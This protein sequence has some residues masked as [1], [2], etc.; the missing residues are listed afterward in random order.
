LALTGIRLHRTVFRRTNERQPLLHPW[1][2]AIVNAMS[3]HPPPQA[4]TGP[5]DS[6]LRQRSPVAFLKV[7]GL[8]SIL[9]ALLLGTVAAVVLR[10]VFSASFSTLLVRT[11]LVSALLLLVYAA[12]RLWV[13]RW[14]PRWLPAWM[15]PV[16]LVAASVVPATFLVYLFVLKGDISAVLKPG[17]VWGGVWI[18]SIGLVFSLLAA[19]TAGVRQRLAEAR[20]T[21]LQFALEKSRLEKQAVDA[22]LALLQSQ[23]EPHF[24]FNTLANVQALVETGS[25]LAADVL[26]SLIAYLRAAMPRLQAGT[27]T[28]SQELALVHAYLD[29]MRMRMPD[30]LTFNIDADPLLL[31]RP[32]PP[33]AALTLVE[34]A[35]RH[36]IDPLERGG[37][38]SVSATREIGGWQVR[39]CDNG[40]GMQAH[41]RPGTGLSNLRER[42]T[43]FYGPAASLILEEHTPQG[44]SARIV[45]PAPTSE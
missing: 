43:G 28:L 40:A 7:L 25:P 30:R 3:A 14:L 18:A 13:P 4:A 20:A 6:R 8:R 16:V 21:E 23:I 24:L 5:E 27:A 10:P 34:N 19:S 31:P 15:W 35:V 33:M 1:H 42:L 12:A 41:S 22:R 9:V 39:V 2:S 45:V 26:K 44:L 32:F 37:R 38:I 11:L 17:R 29:L 36:G